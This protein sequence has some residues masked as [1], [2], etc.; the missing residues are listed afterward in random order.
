[1]TGPL[2]PDDAMD[3]ALEALIG[4]FREE[5]R[6]LLA[7][8]E[9]A[10]MEMEERPDDGE[11]IARAFRALHTIKGSGAMFG[12]GDLEQFSHELEHLFDLLRKKVMPVTPVIVDLA[13]GAKDR[14]LALLDPAGDTPAERTLRAADRARL[15]EILRPVAAAAPAPPA[16]H[17]EPPARDE[18]AGA[19]AA[20]RIIFRP[21]A[22]LFAGGTDPLRVFEELRSL[23]PC[24]V[25][26]RLDAVPPLE[27]IDPG[28][29]Y[30]SWEIALETDRTIGEIRDAFIFVG[31]DAAVEITP[32]ALAGDAT[33][34]AGAPPARPAA[35]PAVPA[36]ADAAPAP[37]PPSPPAQAPAA[38]DAAAQPEHDVRVSA[39]AAVLQRAREGVSTLRVGA[40]KL[41]KLVDLVGEL[42]TVQAS[43]TRLASLRDDAELVGVA[44]AVERLT[45][46]LRDHSLS[47]RMVPIGPAF[48]KFRRLVRDLA[49]DIGRPVEMVTV[50]EDTELDKSII[51]RLNDPIIHLLRNSIDHGIEPPAERARAG[52]PPVGTVMLR[53]SYAGANVVVRVEDDGA[54]IDAAAVRRK[55]VHRGLIAE[56][57]ARP[58]RDLYALLFLPGFSTSATVTNISGRGVGLDVVK[59]AVENLRGQVSIESRPGEGTAF[60]IRIP[61]TLAIIEGLE[62]VLG[63]EHLILPLSAVKECVELVR[64]PGDYGRERSLAE[65]RGELVPFVRMRDFFRVP[66]AAPAREQIVVT[67]FDG[68]RIGLVVDHVVGGQQTV[69]KPLGRL[70]RDV[71]GLA[72]ATILGDG[73]VA[74]ILDVAQLLQ[75]VERAADER[76]GGPSQ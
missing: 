56:N 52:K 27:L 47:V 7:D 65:I 14:L 73:T 10:L 5:A 74:L 75:H 2:G 35:Q 30:L 48:G 1:M 54:G 23:G 64:R 49:H 26:A 25:Q 32:A 62:V 70:F 44:E 36:G 41:D 3:E 59:R 24:T 21:G 13:L 17:V 18:A 50:G 4:T 69:I 33:G 45:A 40:A 12:L 9:S 20:W 57:D 61:L 76:A 46:E 53:A 6:E 71:R 15:A 43:L 34:S 72:G 66:G 28:A 8:M 39:T 42:V 31:G 51:D 22:G 16:A 38:G 55:A 63:D 68:Q 29:C 60:E 58:E 37:L 67:E 19:P 11:L